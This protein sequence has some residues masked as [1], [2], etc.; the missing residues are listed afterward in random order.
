[1][2]VKYAILSI[3]RKKG[4][5]LMTLVTTQVSTCC[6]AKSL[7]EVVGHEDFTWGI[8]SQCHDWTMFDIDTSHDNL[9]EW[10]EDELYK[11]H[12]VPIT[13]P[14]MLNDTQRLRDIGPKCNLPNSIVANFEPKI[15][16]WI[17]PQIG[18]T[19]RDGVL[20]A[21]EDGHFVI[22]TAIEQTNKA[23][24][25]I[26]VE[27]GSGQVL[28]QLNQIKDIMNNVL[29]TTDQKI[30]VHCAMGM[31]RSVLAVVW[32]MANTWG[33]TLETALAKIQE[34]RPI[35]LNRLSWIAL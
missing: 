32:F 31:E 35:A 16:S 12:N 10:D 4:G 3:D 11:I 14:T 26:P 1:M 5:L 18:I 2:V 22:N 34:K 13:T 9:D 6:D 29:T 17:T 23:H 20:Q 30:V 27:A 25:K 21:L 15:I 33:M 28:H 24:I 7:G 8:C 19:S